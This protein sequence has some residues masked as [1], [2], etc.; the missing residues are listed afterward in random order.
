MNISFEKIHG[1]G[2]DFIVVEASV[3]QPDLEWVQAACC[4]NTGVGA[5]GVLVVDVT[6]P[7]M[8]VFNRDGSRPEMCGNGIRCV[9]RYL[10]ERHDFAHDMTIHTDAGPKTCVYWIEDQQVQ[11]DVDM[12]RAGISAAELI[13]VGGHALTI[14]E[15]DM[16][17]PHAVCF[18]DL[19]LAE[20][21][22][23]GM[24]LNDSHPRF[25][26]GVNFECAQVVDG[27]VQVV[28]YER[29][30]GRTMACGTGACATSAA[31]E[32]LGLVASGPTNVVLPGGTLRI[33]NRDQSVWMKG[34]AE[35]VYTGTMTS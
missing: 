17:N 14:V 25:P 27:Q 10:V 19:S 15:V 26:S 2:N 3:F 12:G 22:D 21:D 18:Q 35:S 24:R 32:M 11:V 13:D 31:A 5:D 8:T 30:V 20:I 9:A 33:E 16:G 23:I 34:P 7:S 28:V 29:G 4:R 1:L 6:K